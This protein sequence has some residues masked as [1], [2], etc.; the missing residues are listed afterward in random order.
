MISRA[1]SC[2]VLLL[3]TR[4]ALAD[5][6]VRQVQ[7]ELRKR[8]LYFG[9]VDGRKTAEVRGAIRRYQERKG[10]PATGDLNAETLRSLAVVATGD[11]SEEWPEGTVMKSDAA[12]QIAEAD[13]KVLEELNTE[14]AGPPE[15][16]PEPAA[17]KPEAIAPHTSDPP[18]DVPTKAPDPLALGPESS[19][20]IPADLAE[21]TRAFVRDYLSACTTNS[22][23]AELQFYADRVNYFDHG[24]VDRAFIAK[25][26]QRFYERWPQ[27]QYDLL[28]F[29]IT[30]ARGE[31]RDV[32]F[33]IAFRYKNS[34][35]SVAGRTQNF[36]KVRQDA[37][38]LHFTSLREQRV[39]E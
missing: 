14:D 17:A 13:R 36:F 23:N 19:G 9:D 11:A 10:F 32:S 18:P 26:V 5:E 31:E 20:S 35:Q 2:C 21:Q 12:R 8:N 25:D 1:V 37:D 27:R 22:L 15:P 24:S 4:L 38:G 16:G 28:D 29:K 30:K 33:R 34:R 39:R 3:S 6:Q 7:E